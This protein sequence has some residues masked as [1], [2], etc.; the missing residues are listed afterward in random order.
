MTKKLLLLSLLLIGGL[1]VSCSSDNSGEE[2]P[3]LPPV[4]IEPSPSPITITTVSSEFLIVGENLEITGTNFTNKDY[5]TKI[6]I[7]DIEVTPKEITSSKILLSYSD[8]IK[9]GA[10]TLKIQIQKVNSTPL[11]FFVIAKGWNKLTVLGD[12]DINTSSVFDN[13]NT[14]FSYIKESTPVKL[15]PKA[16]GYTQVSLNVAGYFGA[17]KMFDD[18]RG[19]LTSTTQAIYSTDGFQ[20]SKTNNMP[21][22]FNPIINGLRIGYL[23]DKISI[24]NTQLSSQ[25]YTADNGTTIIKNDA[26]GWSKIVTENSLQA[27]AIVYG[28]GKSTSDGKFY[29]VGYINDYKKYGSKYKNLIM[30]SATGYSDWIAKDT[31]SNAVDNSQSG[32]K[33]ININKI[34]SLHY[35]NKNLSV[36][37]DMLKTWTKIKENVTAFFLR[38]ETQWYIQSGDKLYVTKD[39]GTTWELE[40]ELPAGSVVNDISFSKTKIIVSGKKG[41]HYLKIE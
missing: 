40:L 22:N 26:P 30:E 33:F 18:K 17:F 28:F 25:I 2:A 32:F 13:S 20:T 5:P 1:F 19:V 24:I 37:T 16:S 14:L 34:V 9:S 11:N 36:S 10:N 15:E 21:S 27:R 41:L 38:S 35:T 23:D 4:V 12:V 7:N 39:S 31:I 6:F 8:V 29:Q 3:V